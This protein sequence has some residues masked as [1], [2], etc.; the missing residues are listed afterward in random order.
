M[1]RAVGRADSTD[2]SGGRLTRDGETT[3]APFLLQELGFANSRVF[4]DE[5]GVVDEAVLEPLDPADHVG[6]SIRRAIVVDNTNTALESDLDSHLVLGDGVHGGGYKG[7]L[8]GDALGDGGIKVDSRGGEANVTGQQEEVVVGQT[9]MDLGV[10]EVLNTEP[11][12]A[13]VLLEDLL[14]LGEVQGG[15][16][17]VDGQGTV[18][19][20]H[21]VRK[22][23]QRP[24]RRYYKDCSSV[25]V[26]KRTR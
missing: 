24:D 26:K 21:L 4:G 6:L 10:H 12:T 3:E 16:H 23:E 5:N 1:L 14:G 7:R 13:L 20:R 15:S 22:V 17:A 8:E 9:S 19:G 2:C 18:G 11:I 25:I